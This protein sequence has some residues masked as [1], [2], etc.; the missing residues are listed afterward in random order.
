MDTAIIILII[1]WVVFRVVPRG[2][3]KSRPPAGDGERRPEA[4]R[5]ARGGWAEMLG[6][7]SGEGA[8]PVVVERDK[9]FAAAFDE[10]A[11]P[12]A[13]RQPTQPF[14]EQ[15]AGSL[16]E[17]VSP[18]YD[19]GSLVGYVSPE[20]GAGYA[21]TQHSPQAHEEPAEGRSPPGLSLRW[22]APSIVRGVIL[23]EILA[24]PARAKLARRGKS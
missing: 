22:D 13:R 3:G 16:T 4:K 20:G 15:G 1:L 23:S 17:Y 10:P 6:I 18:V 14:T 19:A 11:P 5:P 7:P 24:R 12:P 8:R 9:G 21:D 2:A